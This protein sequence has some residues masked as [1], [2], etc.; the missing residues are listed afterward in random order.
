MT[1]DYSEFQQKPGD[2][3]L[4]VISEMARDYKAKEQLVADLEEKLKKAQEDFKDIAERKLPALMDE[5]RQLE[6]TTDDGLKIAIKEKLRGSIP[7][8]QQDE[9]FKWLDDHD[10]G[11]LIKREVT[12]SFNRDEEAWAKKFMADLQ[13]RK[14]PVRFKLERSVHPS[15]LASFATEQLEEGVDIPLQTFGLYRQRSAQVELKTDK[16]SRKKRANKDE[17]DF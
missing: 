9:A 3:L 7:K 15:T 4:A 13:K 2:N 16:K 5:A 8:A 11:D 10:H 17:P 14:K 1:H 12:I 6:V